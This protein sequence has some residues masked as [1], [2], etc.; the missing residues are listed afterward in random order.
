MGAHR[1]T[2]LV[3]EGECNLSSSLETFVLALSLKGWAP[4]ADGE[5]F[6][7]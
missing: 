5:A 7:E 6:F 3:D 4:S 2:Q 1:K